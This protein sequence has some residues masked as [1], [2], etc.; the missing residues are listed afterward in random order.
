[1][2]AGVP[3]GA[4]SANHVD[5]SSFGWP[6]YAVVGTPASACERVGD[7]PARALSL[8]AFTCPTTPG[9]S[10]NMACISLAIRFV[11]AWPGAA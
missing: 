10:W 2:A 7:I 8:P 1:M 11:V 4:S 5:D 3:L 6:S 9:T